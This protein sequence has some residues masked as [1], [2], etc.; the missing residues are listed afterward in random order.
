[1]VGITIQQI[2]QLV[3]T[4]SRKVQNLMN[5]VRFEDASFDSRAATMIP[6]IA[7]YLRLIGK[8]SEQTGHY[9]EVSSHLAWWL[10]LVQQV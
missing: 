1:V 9:D 7:T 2:G 3:A 5:K 8:I 4:I 6:I 10:L